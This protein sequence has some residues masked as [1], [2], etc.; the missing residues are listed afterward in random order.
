MFDPDRPSVRAGELR[1]DLAPAMLLRR[2]PDPVRLSSRI[3]LGSIRLLG[4]VCQTGSISGAARCEALTPSAIS[5]RIKELEELVGAPLLVR[6]RDG[7][8]P[9][10]AGRV[11]AGIWA[12]L[13]PILRE[14]PARLDTTQLR[15]DDSLRLVCDRRVARFVALDRFAVPA[16]KS[17]ASRIELFEVSAARVAPGM[18]EMEA[19]IG[20]VQDCSPSTVGDPEPPPGFT[21]RTVVFQRAAFVVRND[22][23]LSGTIPMPTRVAASHRLI[24]PDESIVTVRA[25][26]AALGRA[27]MEF[28]SAL[29][30]RDTGSALEHLDT[31]RC[32]HVMIAPVSVA[33]RIHRFPNLRAVPCPDAWSRVVLSVWFRQHL[34]TSGLVADVLS[35]AFGIVAQGAPPEAP[36]RASDPSEWSQ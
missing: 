29:W 27:S 24:L 31:T 18:M 23:P 19:D 13:E 25:L 28:E 1:D 12:D 35:R 11:V 36:R 9:T 7:V 30:A 15:S 6:Q 33:H 17:A 5:K 26:E 32:D 4:A 22:H 10:H 3:D 21:S 20:V 16:V 14:L 2:A 34:P 8:V